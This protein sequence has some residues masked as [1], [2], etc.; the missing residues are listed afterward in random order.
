MGLDFE[1]GEKIY[2]LC[3]NIKTKQLSIKLNYQKLGLFKIEEQ[4]G[5]VGYKLKLP[6]SI[7]IYLNFH[8]LLLEK[9][10]DN[11]KI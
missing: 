2:L 7:K 3:K 6:K 10:L 1:K 4:L 8:V 9:A 5:L 11:A